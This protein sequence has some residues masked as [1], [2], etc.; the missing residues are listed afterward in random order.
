MIRVASCCFSSMVY[1]LEINEVTD[2][3][4]SK[5][6]SEMALVVRR[7]RIRVK[8]VGKVVINGTEGPLFKVD[9]IVDGQRT[10]Y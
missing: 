1:F 3:A 2:D 5:A 8:R 4:L 7:G 6:G 10:Y 9:N